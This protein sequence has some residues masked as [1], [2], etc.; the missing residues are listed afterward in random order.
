M[1]RADHKIGTGH[2]MR[3]NAL[4][5]ALADAGYKFLLFC[6]S[7]D[8]RLQY[9]C[10]GYEDLIKNPDLNALPA[11]INAAK[12]ALT[13]FDHYFLSADIEKNVRGLK[14]V[15]DDLKRSHVCDLLTD[16]VFF[17]AMR[18]TQILFRPD[19]NCL[20]AKNTHLYA[21]NL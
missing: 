17:D 8:D 16:S 4:L 2:L 15:I 13:L 6:D 21:G 1:L 7:F 11:F 3:V 20:R 14:A 10:K 18:T 5:P 9:A 19:V 12:P